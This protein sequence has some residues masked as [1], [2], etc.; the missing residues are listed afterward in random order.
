MDE[1]VSF[2]EALVGFALAVW[3]GQL[4]RSVADRPTL[5]LHRFD[6]DDQYANPAV[7]IE[8]TSLHAVPLT[9]FGVDMS[10]TVRATSEG[11]TS[12]S[13]WWDW[14]TT[15]GDVEDCTCRE[16]RRVRFLVFGAVLALVSTLG[17]ATHPQRMPLLLCDFLVAALCLYAG[18]L[19]WKV[20]AIDVKTRYSERF[21]TLTFFKPKRPFDLARARHA[22]GRIRALA[23]AGDFGKQRMR[24]NDFPFRAIRGGR[25]AAGEPR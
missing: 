3:L 1:K 6:I 13:N 21:Q 15:I 25:V 9:V 20:V 5:T 2:P 17:L 18:A 10:T 23:A 8:G 24:R 14:S 22:A 7:L 11:L 19:E 12:L 4:F 16:A